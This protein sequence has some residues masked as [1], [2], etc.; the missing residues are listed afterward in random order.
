VTAKRPKTGDSNR[1]R[2]R[3]G[4]A[5]VWF[6]RNESSIDV[7]VRPAKSAGVEPAPI[8]FRISARDFIGR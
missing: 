3:R 4:E 8:C 7:Y 5:R 6:Y 2:V 1:I